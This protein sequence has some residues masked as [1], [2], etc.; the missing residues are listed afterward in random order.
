MLTCEIA[1]LLASRIYCTDG[2]DK[3]DSHNRRSRFLS[4]TPSGRLVCRALL[5]SHSRHSSLLPLHD[6]SLQS[7]VRE[8]F[9]HSVIF[10]AERGHLVE[11]SDRMHFRQ[12]LWPQQETIWGSWSICRQMEQSGSTSSGS[13]STN[14][15][16]SGKG[17]TLRY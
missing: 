2:S 8:V 9:S 10:A 11:R 4:Q 16:G 14:L 1:F 17:T 15:T 12:N 13:V 6:Q 5:F 7:L 3:E